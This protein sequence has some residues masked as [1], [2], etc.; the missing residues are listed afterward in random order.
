MMQN[1]LLIVLV[2][3]FGTQTSWAEVSRSASSL[4][5]RFL[6]VGDSHTEGVFGDEL[7]RLLRKSGAIVAGYGVGG[8]TPR[9]WMT[10]E[11]TPWGAVERT[12]N[13]EVI[14][15]EK[16]ATPLLSVLLKKHRPNRVIVALGTNLIW[17][18]TPESI[19]E[20]VAQFLKLIP[21]SA[22]CIW[23][24]PPLLGP[25]YREKVKT[26]SNVLG[27]S[28]KNSICSYLDSFDVAK[29]PETSGSDQIHFESAG[30]EGVTRARLWAEWVSQ[31]LLNSER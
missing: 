2:L 3:L 29:V 22:T 12:E 15:S 25:K 31:K 9:W 6:L 13:G 20:Q 4:V 10:G 16:I 11:K 18:D 8:S 26:V 21:E 28:L 7:D 17:K 19:R 24:G 23:I 30:D 5:R 27:T 1:L 14:R